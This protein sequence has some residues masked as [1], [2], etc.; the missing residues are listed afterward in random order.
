MARR[1]QRREDTEHFGEE[2]NTVS[3]L[4]TTA[5]RD[6]WRAQGG[7]GAAAKGMYNDLLREVLASGERYVIVSTENGAFSGKKTASVATAIKQARDGKNAPE[8]AE[9]IKV[10]ASGTNVFLENTAIAE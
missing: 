3:E 10:N 8:G 9:N 4:F 6:E 7:G 2:V 1:R 5:S